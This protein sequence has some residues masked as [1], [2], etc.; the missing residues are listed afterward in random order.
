M[1]AASRVQMHG[2]FPKTSAHSL[3]HGGAQNLV[4][5]GKETV[6]KESYWMFQEDGPTAA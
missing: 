4:T 3:S 2:N 6:N 5:R 1:T